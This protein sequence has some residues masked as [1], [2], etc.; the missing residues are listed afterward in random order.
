MVWSF[1]S[2]SVDDDST[3]RLSTG[4]D[5]TIGDE[6]GQKPHKFSR[7]KKRV[8]NTSYGDISGSE[9]EEDQGESEEEW[10]D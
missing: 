7:Y 8:S 9:G 3:G 10:S 6:T 2:S 1:P 4:G 5:C